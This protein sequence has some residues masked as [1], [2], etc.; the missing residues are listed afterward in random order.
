MKPKTH[1]RGESATDGPQRVE[2]PERASISAYL[3]RIERPCRLEDI[4]QALQVPAPAVVALERRLRA[5]IRDGQLICNRRREYGL[6]QQ[7][8]L[9][10]GHVIGHPDGYGFV[11]LEAGGEDL[12]LP[13]RQMRSVLHG[14]R[15]VVRI[16]QS[17]RNN[18]IQAYLVEVLERAHQS[19]VG[20]YLDEAGVAVVVPTDRRLQDITIPGGEGGAAVS[21]D[22]VSLEIIRQPQAHLPPLGR[23]VE[24]LRGRSDYELALT[25][26]VRSHELPEKWSAE[27]QAE[28]AKLPA[29]VLAREHEQREDLRDL[30]LLTIDGED[31][32][33][34]DDAVYCERDGRGWR[35]LVAIADVSHYVRPGTALDHEARR[36]GTSVYFPRSVIPMLP[37][38]LSNDLC[39]LLPR[40]DRLCLAC[41]MH[42]DQDGTLRRKRFFSA[43]M[44]SEARLSYREVAAVMEDEDAG[45][46]QRYR[47]LLPHLSNLYG[48][49]HCLHESR[50][51][52]GLIDF[53]TPEY[54]FDFSAEDR[55]CAVRSQHRRQSHRLIEECMLLANVAAAEQLQE[56]GLPALYRVHDFPD[57]D[58]LQE[59]GKFLARLGLKLQKEHK[60]LQT[61][62]YARL[63][64]Q[65]RQREERHL[66]QTM[67]LRSMPLAVYTGENRGHFGLGFSAYTHFT[68]PIRRYPDLLVHRALR[69]L[70]EG[71]AYSYDAPAVAD[72]GSHCSA[73][74]RQAEQ[75]QRE[76][77]RWCLCDYLSDR[78]G[79]EFSGVV[80]GVCSFGLFVEL[81]GV[82]IDGLVHV[83]SL[84]GDYYHHDAALQSLRGRRDGR[85]FQLAQHLPVR[86][87]R[88]DMEQRRIDLELIREPDPGRRRRR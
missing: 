7:M 38:R 12:F 43:L 69:H 20:Q 39:S 67:L 84:P 86:L 2:I 49:F 58:R 71:S 44:R 48:L 73:T 37:E 9:M 61:A 47:S 75:A 80:S 79:E 76:M 10:I 88:V 68:S 36:R 11:A 40:Q 4:C 70:L 23:V 66:I 65:T 3:Q 32:R 22:Y 63:L 13:P 24:V 8:D 81:K 42:V 62:D 51:R 85:V 78:I 72:Q 59:L 34:F 17:R 46:R 53:D 1:A 21:G 60:S 27:L 33:D 31:A 52:R 26:I 19:L 5:M 16:A 50:C 35:L 18:R 25:L 15:V 56:S 57:A 41:E 14:D 77:N 6:V 74:E 83:T 28:L 55:V 87:L 29:S 30:A 54:A 82:G 64:E 45:L